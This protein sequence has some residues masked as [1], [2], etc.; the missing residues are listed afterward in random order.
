VK[1]LL[2]LIWLIFGGLLMAL[3]YAVVALV[4]FVLI[5]TIPFGIASARIARCSAC[6]R[7]VARSSAA[8]TPAPGR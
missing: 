4:M 8:P 6:G 5:V 1:L 3:G 2:N 7:S